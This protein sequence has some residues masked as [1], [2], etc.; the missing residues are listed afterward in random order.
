LRSKA[1]LI[2]G[3]FVM[4]AL[5]PL[6]IPN[7]SAD[8][9][10]YL[11]VDPDYSYYMSNHYINDGY[12]YDLG[13]T[14]ITFSISVENT[15]YIWN[16]LD[17][18]AI[19]NLTASITTQKDS[20]GSLV[21]IL[22]FSKGGKSTGKCTVDVTDWT[23]VVQGFKADISPTGAEGTYN[24]TV[25]FSYQFAY[26]DTPGHIKWVAG[27]DTDYVLVK[28]SDGLS[29]S[30]DVRVLDEDNYVLTGAIYAGANFQKVGVYVQ[31]SVDDITEVTSIITLSSNA[32]N[33]ITLDNPSAYTNKLSLY[34]SLYFKYRVNVRDG[35][36]AAR[37]KATVEIRYQR[38]DTSDKTLSITAQSIP[39]E[40]I[41][42]FTPLLSVTSPES[43]T[44]SQGTMATNLTG[45]TF[46]NIG[47]TELKNVKVWIDISKYFQENKFYFDG[48]G[49]QKLLV[50]TQSQND[51][52]P[53]MGSWLVDFTY[54]NVFK[55]LPAGEHRLPV[56]YSGYYY[57]TGTSGGSTD[58]KKT[59]DSVYTA[60]K[61]GNLY[62]KVNVVDTYHNFKLVSQSS[63][64]LSTKMDD[65]TL[66]FTV[67]NL[68][69]VDVLYAS[70][71]LGVKDKNTNNKLLSNPN[72]PTS[73]VLDPVDVTIFPAQGTLP[74]SVNADVYSYATAGA[75]ILPVTISGINGND[76][77]AVHVVLNMAVRVNPAP[78]KLLVTHLEYP[79]KI[80]AGG[81]FSLRLEVKNEGQDTARNVFVTVEGTA[82]KTGVSVNAQYPQDV[83]KADSALNPFTVEITKINI[84]D[85]A[86]GESK[87]A[88]YTVRADKNLVP[89][90][91]YLMSVYITY[92]DDLARAWTYDS[93]VSV[94][95][96][97]SAPA[98]ETDLSSAL[99]V[100]LGGLGLIIVAFVCVAVLIKL[101]GRSKK[102][103]KGEPE[104]AM[105]ARTAAAPG[106]GYAYAVPAPSPQEGQ[107]AK[108]CP[109]CQKTVPGNY[110]A[111]PYC[112]NQV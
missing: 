26:Q 63:I 4:S 42:A 100:F 108:T 105:S 64:S 58:Y 102:A 89:G 47:N 110:T 15:K 3:L 60:V 35:T 68:E 30:N 51:D 10:G 33:Y 55:Y 69:D 97:G 75:Y 29:V 20:K 56:G 49:G 48:N 16:Y 5:I 101:S 72:N 106:P 66:A 93:K 50:P 61:G 67:T 70:L 54:I 9:M 84:G 2:V 74:F 43:F 87:N 65:V 95:S 38:L 76:F 39:I 71:Q 8:K 90:K 52:I 31:P 19:R 27:S 99:N 96:A 112:G 17:E 82:A 32:K 94:Y 107:V 77:T 81:T 14:G 34:S 62:I 23:E 91:G 109:A 80:K 36:P 18:Y 57:D 104:V 45:I 83:G 1:V 46:E 98:K 103:K 7:V 88:S 41:V 78:P 73:D 21:T 79:S 59:D 92:S 22:D 11:K 6:G 85:I 12:A 28:I 24:L 40:F 53:I 37:Y 111:C 25:E 86:P 44:V 13:E